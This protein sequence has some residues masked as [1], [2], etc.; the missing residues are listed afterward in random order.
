MVRLFYCRASSFAA[1]PKARPSPEQLA[2]VD[3]SGGFV[4]M[5]GFIFM[6]VI[7]EEFG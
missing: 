3:C 7:V 5:C 4:G 1:S 2:R 6:G